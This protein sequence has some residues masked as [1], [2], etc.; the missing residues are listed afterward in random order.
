LED[1]GIDGSIILKQ[2]LKK[3]DGRY[4]VDCSSSGQ[5]QMVGACEYGNEP[6]G[7]V[8]CENFLSS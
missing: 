8:K 7:S 2:I 1:L 4:G 5:G 3:W 6:M